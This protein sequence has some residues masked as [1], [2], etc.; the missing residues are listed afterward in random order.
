MNFNPI[1]TGPAF[2]G[3]A[4]TAGGGSGVNLLGAAAESIVNEI[5]DVAIDLVAAAAGIFAALKI[6]GALNKYKCGG[7]NFLCFKV[8]SL[9]K[10]SGEIW[11]ARLTL[12]IEY[13]TA[14]EDLTEKAIVVQ[15]C[16]TSSFVQDINI[17]LPSARS[18]KKERIIKVY[19]T[20]REF[21]PLNGI[22]EARFKM[23]ASVHS[24][25]EYVTGFFNYPNTAMIGTR[26]NSKDMPNVPKRE[27]V[28]KGK[29][30]KIPANY[31]PQSGTYNLAQENNLTIGGELAWTSNPAWIIYD[32]L[33]NSI[34]GM[35]K[36][37]IT[38][39]EIDTWSFYQFSK[40]CD[41]PVDVTIE[42]TS[43]QER[44]FMCNLYVDQSRPA[45]EY[46]KD[47]LRM[48]NSTLNFTGGKIYINCDTKGDP[49]MLFNN[50]N[51]S[52][53][54]FSYSS[55]P[56]TSRVSACTVDYLDERDFYTL[57]SEYFEDHQSIAE[58]GYIHIKIPGNGIT[59][60]GEALRL[61]KHKVYSKQLEKEII[62]FTCGLTGSYLKIGDVIEVADNNRNLSR[63][64]G[65]I[66][67]VDASSNTIDLDIPTS[68]LPTGTALKVQSGTN[69]KN[70]NI[71]SK[72]NFS[73]TVQESV[74]TISPGDTWSIPGQFDSDESS[75]ASLRQYRVSSIKESGRLKFT[76]V[77]LEYV[78]EKYAMVES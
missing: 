12:R 45:Y 64:T 18:S 61:A 39:N 32:L 53:E 51:V 56:K 43:T 40:I 15:G 72:N 68:L 7:S 25:T 9:I 11:P 65:S 58:Y 28:I 16:A 23:S 44:R 54:G 20:T 70:L 50:S 67:N 66:A 63:F 55:T 37:G 10:N 24:I 74:S 49:V 35:G 26:F 6:M 30:V 5:V 14:G 17:K 33:T 2:C 42:E 57:K 29:L 52:E 31:S 13:G 46:I 8:G 48:Y 1:N 75:T 19:R 21:N 77:A 69:I 62:E 71:T 27:Y 4:N 73:V 22:T 60:K 3:F 59:R 36:Y 38:S 41:E 76:I 34:Y 78:D 47:L